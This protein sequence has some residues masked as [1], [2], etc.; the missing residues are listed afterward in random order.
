MRALPSTLES[1]AK[2]GMVSIVNE[3]KEVRQTSE[4]MPMI[5]R[6]VMTKRTKT[7]QKTV[8]QLGTERHFPGSVFGS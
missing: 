5:R 6:I 2:K 1:E 4:L 7:T 8:F 3:G